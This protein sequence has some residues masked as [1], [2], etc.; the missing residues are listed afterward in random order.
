MREYQVSYRGNRLVT[1]DNI[2]DVLNE[3]GYRPSG[4]GGGLR[5]ISITSWYL[6]TDLSSG[7]VVNHPEN[8]TL[9]NPA[10][11]KP[12]WQIGFILPDPTYRYVWKFS[13]YHYGDPDHEEIEGFH[14]Y[15]NC[16]LVS[17]YSSSDTSMGIDFIYTLFS[18]EVSA[19]HLNNDGSGDYP[20]TAETPITDWTR[21]LS[22]LAYGV[23]AYLWMSQRK[24]NGE[25]TGNWSIPIRLSGEDGSPGADGVNIQFCYKHMNRLPIPNS[26]YP[27]DNPYS[28][29]V[30]DN[31]IPD[32]WNNH[33]SGVGYFT[34]TNNG[35]EQ[36]VFYRYE[37]A[38]YR[39]RKIEP[40]GSVIWEPWSDPF[41]WSAYGEKGMDGDG[42]EYV[43]KLFNPTTDNLAPEKP[44]SPK[45]TYGNGSGE[46][47]WYGQVYLSDSEHPEI[48]NNWRPKDWEGTGFNTWIGGKYGPQG[49][50]IPEG[51]EDDPTGVSETDKVEWVSQRK[52]TNSRW[53]QFSDPTVWATFSKEHTVEI[54]DGY[55]WI[56]GKPTNHKA[57]GEDGKG[58]DLKGRVDVYYETDKPAYIQKHPEL[59]SEQIANLK[60]LQNAEGDFNLGSSNVG[61]CFVVTDNG[62]IYLYVGGDD[63]DWEKHWHD[64]GEFQGEG[65]YVHIAWAHRIFTNEL[66]QLEVDGFVLDKNTGSGSIEYEWMGICTDNESSDPE[67]DRFTEYKWNYVHGKDGTTFERVY[68]R[69]T[70]N[71]RPTIKKVDDNYELDYL[72]HGY[73][74][75]G[76][77]YIPWVGNYGECGAENHGSTANPL[78]HFT[79]DP[80]GANLNYPYEWIAERRKV[81]GIWQDFNPPTL[82]TNFSHDGQSIIR[83]IVFKRSNTKPDA[84]VGGDFGSPYPTDTDWK[85]GLPSGDGPIWMSNKIFTSD[86]ESPQDG[87]NWSDP[88][89]LRDSGDLDIEFSPQ[90]R[91]ANPL[92]EPIDIGKT[93]AN[94]HD[95]EHPSDSNNPG[96]G[97]QLWFDP[98]LDKDY[99]NSHAKEMNWMATRTSFVNPSTNSSVWRDWVILLIK[100]EAGAAGKSFDHAYIVFPNDKDIFDYWTSNQQTTTNIPPASITIG[101]NTYSWILN[102]TSSLNME[103][104]KALWMTERM[105]S[106][107]VPG[108]W[109]DPVKISGEGTPGEDAEDIEFIYKRSDHIPDNSDNSEDRPGTDPYNGKNYTDNDYVPEGWEDSPLGVDNSPE[110]KYEWMCQRIKPRSNSIEDPANPWGPWSNIFVW[111]AYGDTGMDGDSIEYVYTRVSNPNTPSG[112]KIKT[113]SSDTTGTDW[114][115]NVENKG[116]SQNPNWQPKDYTGNF[117]GWLGGEYNKQGEWIPTGWTDEPKGVGEFDNPNYD[118]NDENS[119]EKITYLKEYVSQRKRVNGEW[120]TFS[121]PAV[122]STYSKAQRFHI[123][124]GKWYD[125]DDNYIGDAEGPQGQGIQ[126]KGTVDVVKISEKQDYATAN[127]V[128]VNTVTSLQEVN[129][130]LNNDYSDIKPGDCYVV[131]NNRHLYVCLHDKDLWNRDNESNTTTWE[132]TLST[133]NTNPNWE[134]VGEFQG[135]PGEGSYMH[136]AWATSNDK[137]A[138]G[139]GTSNIVFTN[140]VISEIKHYVVAYEDKDP[141]IDY[142]WMGVLTDHNKDDLPSNYGE[143]SYNSNDK[144]TWNWNKYK[145]N[146]V[147]GRDGDNYERVYLR[148]KSGIA[149]SFKD[150]YQD[151]SNYQDPEYLPE[152]KD[153]DSNQ[154]SGTIRSNKCY[155]TDDPVGVEV[156]WPYEWMAERKKK[157]D[158]ATNIVRWFGFSEPALWAKYSF[159][160]TPGKGF[161]VK[162]TVASIN[163][164]LTISNPNS[165]NPTSTYADSNG[166][167]HTIGWSNNTSG[168]TIDKSN[169]LWMTQRAGY[170]GDWEPWITP[171]CLS[172]KDGE[173]GADGTNIE[174]IYKRSNNTSEAKPG[175]GLNTNTNKEYKDEDYVPE[176]WTDNPQGVSPQFKYEWACQRIKSPGGSWNDSDND[177]IGPFIWSAYGDTGMDGDGLEYVFLRVPDA[178]DTPIG[179]RAKKTSSPST[180]LMWYGKVEKIG[181]EWVPVNWDATTNEAW[182]NW[183]WDEEAGYFNDP[184]GEWIP[185]AYRNNSAI[186]NG[187]GGNVYWSDDPSGVTMAEGERREWVSTRQKINGN[188]NN[189]SEPKLWASFGTDIYIDSDGNWVING[190]VSGKAEGKDGKG[191]A[192]R[193][194]VDF[195]TSQELEEYK[196]AN[197]DGLTSTELN[198]LTALQQIQPGNSIGISRVDVGDCYVVR[199]NRYLYTSKRKFGSGV[200]TSDSDYWYTTGQGNANWWKNGE[201]EGPGQQN[202]AEVGEFQGADGEDGES[203]FIHIAWAVSENIHWS[204]ENPN[205]IENISSFVIAYEEKDSNVEYDWMGIC[206]N[207]SEDDP[208][209]WSEYKWNHVKGKDGSDYEKVYVRSKLETPAPTVNQNSYTGANSG[210]NNKTKSEF[211]PKVSNYSTNSSNFSSQYFTDDPHGVSAGWPYEWVAERRKVLNTNTQKM[212]WGNFDS[213]AK[214]WAKYSF[215][216]LTVELTRGSDSISIDAAGN[217]IGGYGSSTSPRL[218]TEVKVY[219]PK[220]KKE[221]ETYGDFLSYNDTNSEISGQFRINFDGTNCTAKKTSD[222]KV[223]VE[224]IDNTTLNECAINITVVVDGKYFPK[225][226]PVTLNHIPQTYLT[227]TLTNDSDTYTY[228]TRTQQYDGLPIETRLEVKTTDGIVDGLGDNTNTDS[229]YIKSVKLVGKSNLLQYIKTYNG[230]STTSTT[231]V[232]NK[233]IEVLSTTSNKIVTHHKK[234]AIIYSDSNR[235]NDTGLRLE[236]C[237]DGNIKLYRAGNTTDIDL[238]D[239][240][241]EFDITCVAI[242]GGVEYNS[243]TKTFTITEKNDATLYK[244]LLSSDTFIKNENGSYDPEENTFNVKVNVNDGTGTTTVTPENGLIRNHVFVRYINGNSTGIENDTLLPDRPTFTYLSEN[245]LRTFTVLVVEYDNTNTNP[246]IYHDIETV[247]IVP[248]GVSQTYLDLSPTQFTVDC[249]KDGNILANKTLTVTAYL[250]WGDQLC[251]SITG[252]TMTPEGFTYTGTNAACTPGTISDLTGGASRTF[253]FNREKTLTSGIIK[254][255]LTGTFADGVSRTARGTVN[256]QASRKG[257]DGPTGPAGNFKSTA[258]IRTYENISDWLPTGGSYSSPKPTGFSGHD[259]PTGA[260]WSDGIPEG[261]ETLWSSIATFY[262][263]GAAH[264]W[265]NP[266]IVQDSEV[267]DVEFALKQSNGS[268]PNSP[269]KYDEATSTNRC[270]SHKPSPYDNTIVTSQIWYDP[271]ED[272]DYITDNYDK[273]YWKAERN[274]INNVK[275]PWIITQIKGESE[276]NIKCDTSIIVIETDPTGKLNEDSTKELKTYLRLGETVQSPV[277]TSCSGSSSASNYVTITRG[278]RINSDSSITWT[279]TAKKDII[280]SNVT[281]TITMSNSSCSATK[282]IDIVFERRNRS[283]FKSFVFKRFA[284]TPSASDAPSTTATGGSYENNGLPTGTSGRDYGWSDGLPTSGT[285]PIYMSSRIFYSD[286]QPDNDSWSTPVMMSDTETFNVEFSPRTSRPVAPSSSNSHNNN[287]QY[288]YTNQVWFDPVLDKYSAAGVERDFSSMIWMATSTTKDSS[289]NWINWAIVKIKGETGDTGTGI[290]SITTWYKAFDTLDVVIPSAGNETDGWTEEGNL[291]GAGWVKNYIKPTKENP[292]LWKFTRTVYQHPYKVVH[293]GLEMIQVWSENMINPNLLEDTEFT[294]INH[295]SAWTQAGKPFNNTYSGTITIG[296]ESNAYNNKNSFYVN[297]SNCNVSIYMLQQ[298]VTGKIVPSE[299]YTLS[300]W[301]K[302]SKSG[303]NTI[304][305]SIKFGNPSTVLLDETSSL[306]Y[307]NDTSS[308]QAYIQL[309]NVSNSWS[310][311]TITFKSSD[312]TSS[313]YY[314]Y[315]Q[316]MMLNTTGTSRRFDFCMPK[317]EIGKVATDYVASLVKDPYP[318]LTVW[319]TGKQYYRGNYGEPY[320]DAVTYGA[321]WFRCRNTHISSDSN[322][323]VANQTT[324]YWEPANN[325]DFVVTDLLLAETGYIKNLIVGG[326]RTG[327]IGTPHVEMQGSSINFFGRKEFANIRMSVDSEG[328]AFLSFYDNTNTFLYDLGPSGLRWKVVV[329]NASFTTRNLIKMSGSNVDFQSTDSP[330]TSLYKF[331][332]KKEDGAIVGDSNYTNGDKTIAESANGKYFTSQIFL[333]D[334]GNGG[335]KI[336]P[337]KLASGTFREKNEPVDDISGSFVKTDQDKE[338]FLNDLVT[339]YSFPPDCTDEIDLTLKDSGIGLKTPIMLQHGMTFSNGSD[340]AIVGF[341]QGS[342]TWLSVL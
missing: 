339:F 231:A 115:G 328:M 212:E 232:T 16:E 171:V 304:H 200:N 19:V 258:F 340:R 298:Y 65:A 240:K 320:L 121:D 335:K 241:H 144:N 329:T 290:S 109:G 285:D 180:T 267:Y 197:P 30:N 274:I 217:V 152:V 321:N 211:Y 275:G 209:V 284:S 309:K 169:F 78:Y 142:D 262:G 123:V 300:F 177:W 342:N 254:V 68:V 120:G 317:L 104:D 77:E 113:S 135:K 302:C 143:S 59:T 244:L 175:K 310:R 278:A 131:R 69:T 114:A 6:K 257:N 334:D 71:I 188:W 74:E 219:D 201:N 151:D 176:G 312:P 35:V 112:P 25:T 336:D 42:V 40:E 50:W 76:Y 31:E 182:S 101:S 333:M 133:S 259:M 13:D 210:H 322:K 223:Y 73:Q 81:D 288:G 41:V 185:R 255:T 224:S 8:P 314:E 235:R 277:L 44:K 249:D 84:P 266:I 106:N 167:T 4:D 80:T 214:L 48:S 291:T 43:Y 222:G 181:D 237:S 79:D 203:Q 96:Y 5:L 146:N 292:Y 116:T 141:N 12:G 102:D 134:D 230:A 297:S 179:P 294:D 138:G 315:I 251:E 45:F 208:E 110:H 26:E 196:T 17:I 207:K 165:D 170:E 293:D 27:E 136:I 33:P 296:I 147:R 140:G 226:F 94:R 103:P 56:D 183:Q 36:E 57:E 7:V 272:K 125:E 239:A 286:G 228:R 88:I 34:E 236:V 260:E 139:Y 283:Q 206:R 216:G 248:P 263:S 173:P 279:I 2:I 153:Y 119:K 316:F 306:N 28:Q 89:L 191:V 243:I 289:G 83:S 132:A 270:N 129:P 308:D 311:R 204:T 9:D 195:L 332:P 227:Y 67:E 338:E 11:P 127:E 39:L 18:K 194:S 10:P 198:K 52:F 98:E 202:W 174:F 53:G 282:T 303:S 148:T 187:S 62:H 91:D 122:W 158:T 221:D 268:I 126:L 189:F 172:G 92:V 38:T 252:K 60:S 256:I 164:G 245:N 271:V 70:K 93:G 234:T 111:S 323:P 229:G 307:S 117:Y 55:W 20:D 299:W 280:L 1:K 205:E 130:W 253:T 100:G 269:V 95:P 157:L 63:E 264:T 159:D 276:P 72:G 23:N 156:G 184:Q 90:P 46:Y 318:R 160:G 324:A 21:D 337:S 331:I 105:I 326:L 150:N 75:S 261:E 313:N 193:G 149:P 190:V 97:G 108:V 246:Q 161:Q 327:D 118:P 107:D 273:F 82:H 301:V 86:G 199:K 341:K 49:E 220:K 295:I 37:W 168:L 154:H 124:D 305:V 213:P 22:S 225:V 29:G 325:L 47:D 64:F 137:R 85:D 218:Y 287:N 87:L 265:S 281:L 155:F 54:K 166:T 163:T 61:D 319:G 3:L 162:Y 66:G 58:I 233:T 186:T 51:W 242:L 15:T 192:L 178:P 32:G 238:P 215:D 99:I 247:D 128:N 250:K 330:V 145:W 24:I 14:I